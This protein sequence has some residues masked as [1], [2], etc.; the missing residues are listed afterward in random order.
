MNTTER[1]D[2]AFTKLYNAFHEGRLEALDCTMCAVGNICDGS[3]NWEINPKFA[4]NTIFKTWSGSSSEE[5]TKQG[6]EDIKKSGYSVDELVNVELLFLKA[7]KNTNGTKEQQFEGL[8]AVVEYLCKLDS[9]PNVI[10]Y[11]KLFET[12]NDKPKYQLS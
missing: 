2:N 9:I 6:E 7:C 4:R 5:D 12:E 8:C 1:F 10:D 11:T 3:L